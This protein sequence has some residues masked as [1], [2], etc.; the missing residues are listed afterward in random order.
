MKGLHPRKDTSV[1]TVLLAVLLSGT[2][3][4]GVGVRG[5]DR[6]PGPVTHMLGGGARGGGQIDDGVT[7]QQVSILGTQNRSPPRAMTP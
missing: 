7:A 6:A 3:L 2:G 1:L 5:H 4:V